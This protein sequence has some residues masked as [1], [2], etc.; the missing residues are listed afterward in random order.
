MNPKLKKIW[1][2]EEKSNV[3][4]SNNELRL[5]FD[6]DRHYLVAI[7]KGDS[8]MMVIH[9]LKCKLKYELL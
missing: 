7:E 1:I 2:N 8:R 9:K 6:N 3:V 5:D 4:I